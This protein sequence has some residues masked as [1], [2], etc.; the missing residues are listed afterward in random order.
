MCE[1]LSVPF[2]AK[3]E[4]GNSIWEGRYRVTGSWMAGSARGPH[5]ASPP[6]SKEAFHFSETKQ[7]RV[8]HANQLVEG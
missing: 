2:S 5:M 4:S 6:V 1:L 3:V 8:G 7:A